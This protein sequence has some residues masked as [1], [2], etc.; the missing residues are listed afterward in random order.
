MRIAIALALLATSCTAMPPL[1]ASASTEARG[2]PVGT[3]INMGNSLEPEQEGSWGG[4]PI[5]AE[6]FTIIK[7]AGFDTVRIPVRWHNKSLSEPP[8]TIEAAW[9]DR[10]TEVVGQAL[11]ADLNVILNSHHFDPIHE[12]PLGV[13]KWHGGVWEQIAQRFA[14]Y[15][16]D[17]LWF[18]LENEPHNK[19]DN[20]NLLE[21]LAP[22][23]AAVR[24]RQGRHGA[25]DVSESRF[26]WTE[27]HSVHAR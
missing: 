22:G 26:W 16:E 1:P 23:L 4:H 19:F 5:A 18:E 9:M 3:C 21:T 7:Q 8:Y 11:A 14:D 20:D 10:V 2:L 25:T 15:P 6:D 24:H 12:D 27:I 17:R 13:S